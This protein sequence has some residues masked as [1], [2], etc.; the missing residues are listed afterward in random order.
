MPNPALKRTATP[1]LSFALDR[2][3]FC[4]PQACWQDSSDITLS[5]I[6][7]MN[8]FEHKVLFQFHQITQVHGR[9]STAK[10]SSTVILSRV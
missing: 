4:L 2:H 6:N 9:C 10:G 3:R 5:I 1:P 8:D 7:D